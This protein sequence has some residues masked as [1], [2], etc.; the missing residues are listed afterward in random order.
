MQVGAT[1]LHTAVAYSQ[2][3]NV[4]TL[5][6]AGANVNARTNVSTTDHT[7]AIRVLTTPPAL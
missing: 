3:K 5:I 4:R 6:E 1:P 2:L 7:S